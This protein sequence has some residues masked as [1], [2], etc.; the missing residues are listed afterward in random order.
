[1]KYFFGRFLVLFVHWASY[2]IFAAKDRPTRLAIRRN[3][4][5]SARK[6]PMRL[7]APLLL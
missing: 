1:M 3:Y 7:T 6:T 2:V 4:L 5:F